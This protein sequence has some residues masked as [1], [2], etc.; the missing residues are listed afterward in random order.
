MRQEQQKLAE[1]QQKLEAYEQGQQQDQSQA[2]PAD[3]DT[4]QD[5]E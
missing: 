3:K 1:M 4:N 5:E 2:E